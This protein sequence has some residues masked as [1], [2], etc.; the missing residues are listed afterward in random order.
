M[1]PERAFLLEQATACRQLA[2]ILNENE[3]ARLRK[4]ADE[5]ETVAQ[6]SSGDPRNRQDTH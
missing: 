6:I 1:R 3:G 2:L 4:L 5:Y